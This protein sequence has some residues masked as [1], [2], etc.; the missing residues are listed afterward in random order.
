MQSENGSPAKAVQD[1][2]AYVRLRSPQQNGEALDV[3]AASKVDDLFE[4]NLLLRSKYSEALSISS[5]VA[6]K[7]V[8][9]AAVNYTRRYLPEVDVLV[10]SPSL[11]IAC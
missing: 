5:S 2:L 9:D 11:P 1:H 6:R 10:E 7:Q 8:F 3:P 4:A